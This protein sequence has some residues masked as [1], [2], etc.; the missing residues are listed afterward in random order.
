MEL[1]HDNEIDVPASSSLY[2]PHHPVPNKNGDKFSEQL[3]LS[4]AN[5]FPLASKASLKYFYIDDL[6]SGANSLSEALELQNHLTQILSSAGLVL[7]KWASNCNELLNSIGSDMR[8]PNACLNIDDHDTVKTL[9]IQWN[10]V[11]DVFY[12]KISP[13]FEGTLTERTLLS[14]IGKTFHPLRWLSPITIQYKTIMQRLWK[15]QLQ[16]DE[17]VPPDITFE[18]EQLAKD[19]KLVKDIKI[20]RF[21][22]VDSD[23]QFHLFGFS[24]AS[25]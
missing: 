4:E 5:H 18:W 21:L 19:V 14:T 16:W 3:A 17:S 25:E 20:R 2:L 24:G 6:M 15:Q 11:S 23:N 13:Y 8:L 12:F 22:F 1:I 7:K 10:P 9:G